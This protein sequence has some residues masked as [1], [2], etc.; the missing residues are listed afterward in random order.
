MKSSFE[1]GYDPNL[2]R[3][4]N[5]ICFNVL[6]SK[7]IRNNNLLHHSPDYI[8]EKYNHFIGFNPVV[9]DNKKV[10]YHDVAGYLL[11]TPVDLTNF[12][13]QYTKIWKDSSHLVIRQLHYLKNTENLCIYSMV[14]FFEKYIGPINQ[15]SPEAKI[16]LHPHLNDFVQTVLDKNSGKIDIILRDMKLGEL[17]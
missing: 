15:I 2:E 10:E 1:G 7:F 16:G 11:Y 17:I 6:F 14:K 13:L 5:L 9:P 4:H 8:L 12:F 3:L